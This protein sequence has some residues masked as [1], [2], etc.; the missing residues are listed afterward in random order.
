MK[1]TSYKM[2]VLVRKDLNMSSGKISAQVAH[3]SVEA[4]L[5][6]D[7]EDISNWRSEGMKKIILKVPDKIS[8]IK[9]K[10]Q[11]EKDDIIT[12]LITDA[13]LT[14]LKKAEVTCL[15]IG[16]DKEEKIDKITGKLKTL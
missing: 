15:A 1:N 4:V 6:S 8:L 9:Y 10:E 2:V 5:R 14:E 7:K 3:A 16:P 11:A 12:A 13:G